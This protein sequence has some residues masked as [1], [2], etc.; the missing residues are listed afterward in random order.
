V[1]CRACS[2]P[3]SSLLPTVPQE[4]NPYD[5]V[6]VSREQ[7]NPS[8]F[9]IFTNVSAGACS[10]SSA[11]LWACAPALWLTSAGTSGCH[12]CLSLILG[13]PTTCRPLVAHPPHTNGKSITWCSLLLHLV[14]TP[15]PDPHSKVV[16]ALSCPTWTC[17]TDG[18]DAHVVHF[19]PRPTLKSGLCL[20]LP[21]LHLHHRWA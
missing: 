7:A 4:Y 19:S 3:H 5:L 21:N 11:P 9:Y 14:F 17:T 8:F 1:R 2:R 15:A 16:C 13:D 20:R 18:R 6:V 12:H 10:P